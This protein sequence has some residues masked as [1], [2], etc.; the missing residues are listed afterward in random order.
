LAGHPWGTWWRAPLRWWPDSALPGF[1]KLHPFG[2]PNRQT[3]T[4]QSSCFNGLTLTLLKHKRVEI[5]LSILRPFSCFS[6]AS[7]L[8]APCCLFASWFKQLL[9]S[10]L[11]LFSPLD[12]IN[13]PA[14]L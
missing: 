9:P 2:P 4:P 14:K 13:G 1:S 8:A 10:A 3:F 5:V 12:R 11:V 6:L 7:S